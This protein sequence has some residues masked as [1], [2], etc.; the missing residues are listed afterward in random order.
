MQRRGCA[1]SVTVASSICLDEMP[2][3]LAEVVMPRTLARVTNDCVSTCMPQPT[4]CPSQAGYAIW[5]STV[6]RGCWAA[7]LDAPQWGAG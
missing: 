1:W 7:A 3:L 6:L 5:G 4:A 2:R